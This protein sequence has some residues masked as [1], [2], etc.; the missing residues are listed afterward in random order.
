MAVDQDRRCWRLLAGLVLAGIASACA[1]TAGPRVVAL[2]DASLRPTFQIDA[3]ADYGVAIATIGAIAERDLGFPPFPL[4]FHFHADRAAL[5]AALLESGYHPDLA[6]QTARTMDGIGGHRR[7]L[8]NEGAMARLE[9]RPRV[10]M[11]AHEFAHSV[12]YEL[13][14][15]IRGASDQWLREGF[16]EWFSVKVMERLKAWS[17]ADARRRYQIELRSRRRSG[18][19]RLDDMVTFPQWVALGTQRHRAPYAQAFL[20]VDFLIERHGVERVIDYFARFAR[21]QDRLGNFLEAF[22]ED[23]ASFETAL[24]E[25]LAKRGISPD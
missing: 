1:T 22:G 21:R 14:G 9:W 3:I 23:L 5:E 2:P 7:I 13:G 6:R 10:A 15:G 18:M 16:A 20:A 19:L 12:Q 24:L 4:A 11:L 25:S 8:L 17:L